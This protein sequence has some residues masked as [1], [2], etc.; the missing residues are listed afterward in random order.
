[1]R[2]KEVGVNRGVGTRQQPSAKRSRH[3]MAE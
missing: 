3:V 1:M 2:K